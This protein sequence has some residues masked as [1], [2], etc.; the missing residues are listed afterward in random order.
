MEKN[1]LIVDDSSTARMIIQRCCEIAGLQG[2][3]FF[4][5]ASG[6]KALQ[7]LE[8]ERIDLVLSDLNMPEMDGRELTLALRRDERFTELPVI[9]ITSAK[10]EKLSGELKS[11]GVS[12]VLGKPITPATL[13]REL[14]R[15]IMV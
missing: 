8:A 7:V 13:A 1:I 15:A 11:L 12:A 10:S 14:A 5:A 9:V 6:V 3:Q 2:S 4:Q